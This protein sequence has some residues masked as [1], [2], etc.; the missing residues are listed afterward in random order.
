M[1]IKVTILPEGVSRRKSRKVLPATDPGVAQDEFNVEMG[2]QSEA[3]QRI[4]GE[5]QYRHHVAQCY[6]DE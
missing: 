2:F 3:M 6:D 4:R 5:K 1:G